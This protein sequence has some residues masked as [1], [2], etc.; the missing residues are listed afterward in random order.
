MLTKQDIIDYVDL[1]FIARG[2]IEQHSSK[3]IESN[4]RI[5]NIYSVVVYDLVGDI[6]NIST[7]QFWVLDENQPLERA[8]WFSREPKPTIPQNLH[9]KLDDE[10]KSR[11]DAGTIKA[12]FIKEMHQATNTATLTVVKND[13]DQALFLAILQNDGTFVFE[14]ITPIL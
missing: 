11:V 7:V 2:S 1:K 3:K 5:L 8:G 12:A 4:G 10:I 13:G 9:Q 14:D 6:L